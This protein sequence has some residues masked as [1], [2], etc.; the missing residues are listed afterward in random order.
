MSSFS[1]PYLKD[2]NNFCIKL[3]VDCVPGRKGCVLKS[4]F[5]FVISPEERIKQKELSKKSIK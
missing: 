4:K 5:Q 3:N 2:E 1:C